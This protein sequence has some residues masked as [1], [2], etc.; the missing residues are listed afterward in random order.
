MRFQLSTRLGMG[1]EGVAIADVEFEVE[2]GF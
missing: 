1:M 2:N